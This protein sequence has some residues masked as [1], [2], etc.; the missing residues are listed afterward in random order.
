MRERT[1]SMAEKNKEKKKKNKLLQ[2]MVELERNWVQMVYHIWLDVWNVQQMHM[3]KILLNWIQCTK[4]D[5]E[6]WC[7]MDGIRR[8]FVLSIK[9]I[10]ILEDTD[11]TFKCHQHGYADMKLNCLRLL[12]P[13]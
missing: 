2:I 8:D 3:M 7:C 1:R 13:N 6:I 9:K 5:C 4:I 10:E 11:D 12:V